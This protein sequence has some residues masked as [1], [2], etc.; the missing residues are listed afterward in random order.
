MNRTSPRKPL[1]PQIAR[2]TALSNSEPLG[3]TGQN[4]TKD[5]SLHKAPSPLIG[6]R[7]SLESD[8]KAQRV[9]D[10]GIGTSSV[11]RTPHRRGGTSGNGGV[12][13]DSEGQQTLEDAAGKLDEAIKTVLPMLPDGAAKTPI[14]V[15]ASET[16]Y[17]LYQWRQG[18]LEHALRASGRRIA[19]E[20]LVPGI[21]NRS[22][23]EIA[24]RAPATPLSKYAESAYKKTMTEILD[25]GV[26][27]LAE[28]KRPEEH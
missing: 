28:Y 18:G 10:A 5:R 12:A 6:D 8:E 16:V 17:F 13:R 26:D 22:W 15:G 19:E 14:Y 25:K 11:K 7:G 21:V 23:T 27:A 20:Y 1:R 24:S 3:R 2:Q 4:G 9:G